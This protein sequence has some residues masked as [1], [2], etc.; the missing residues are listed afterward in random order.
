MLVWHIFHKK[1]L[2]SEDK[3]GGIEIK[4]A[5]VVSLAAKPLSTKPA[6]IL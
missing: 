2:A 3:K 1:Y 6:Y 5:D 4:S